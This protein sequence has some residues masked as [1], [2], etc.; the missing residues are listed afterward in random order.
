VGRHGIAWDILGRQRIWTLYQAIRRKFSGLRQ[1][2]TRDSPIHLKAILY[3]ESIRVSFLWKTLWGSA[4]TPKGG[5]HRDEPP[6]RQ[7]CSH[8]GSAIPGEA[9]AVGPDSL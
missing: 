7:D 1:T 6:T 2:L 5:S 3:H 4:E 8:P 9:M